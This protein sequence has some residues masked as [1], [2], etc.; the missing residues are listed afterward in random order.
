MKSSIISIINA[1]SPS[2]PVTI[3]YT[4]L[5][6]PSKSKP[7]YSIEFN[8]R[9]S[10]LLTAEV[11][12][13]RLL[14]INALI[15]RIV[16]NHPFLDVFESYLMTTTRYGESPYPVISEIVNQEMIPDDTF[17]HPEDI[18][19]D[20]LFDHFLDRNFIQDLVVI[21]D[22]KSKYYSMGSCDTKFFFEC[23]DTILDWSQI[24]YGFSN[25]DH[26]SL[27]AAGMKSSNDASC[28]DADKEIFNLLSIFA[29]KGCKVNVTYVETTSPIG[30]PQIAVLLNGIEVVEC[31]KYFLKSW[32]VKIRCEAARMA[33]PTF[34][35]D[36]SRLVT[37]DFGNN[38]IR[39]DFFFTNP[40]AKNN[41]Y[42]NSYSPRSF[43][44]HYTFRLPMRHRNSNWSRLQKLASWANRL[45]VAVSYSHLFLF[46][47]R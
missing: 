23:A 15:R 28:H 3:K 4:P 40:E 47:S 18:T 7:L 34:T 6:L 43:D 11:T 38:P 37:V 12:F 16:N 35:Y 46:L 9:Y 2:S 39:N 25:Y 19:Y 1:I 41:F 5:N 14:K 42:R 29:S 33:R 10:T 22:Y 13:S 26:M 17:F 21:F 30:S 31:P 20:N 44:I 45:Q 27:T 32:I 24:Q 8:A 36:K